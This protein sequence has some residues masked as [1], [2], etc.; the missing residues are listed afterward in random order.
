MAQVVVNAGLHLSKVGRL[1]QALEV[2]ELGDWA[3]VGEAAAQRSRAEA[4]EALS[5]VEAG[6][7]EIERNL[8]ARHVGWMFAVL[9]LV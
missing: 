3:Q 7:D 6:R 8:D 4:L 2:E 5:K 1:G 9:V